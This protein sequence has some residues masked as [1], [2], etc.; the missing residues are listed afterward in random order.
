MASSRKLPRTHV[1]GS[2]AV[3]RFYPETITPVE[4]VWKYLLGFNSGQH[5]TAWYEEAMSSSLE[6]CIRIMNLNNITLGNSRE[7][8][9]PDQYRHATTL[10]PHKVIC[11]LLQVSFYI[12]T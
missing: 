3:P 1:P 12:C 5:P 8:S 9:R 10:V 7:G 6:A 4:R 11:V 2:P